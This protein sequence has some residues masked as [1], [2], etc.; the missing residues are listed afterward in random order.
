[1]K[2]M[3]YT[4]AA[5]GA[6]P[7]LPMTVGYL[8]RQETRVRPEGHAS[9]QLLCV[10]E[11]SGYL[12]IGGERH[13]LGAGD[14]IFLPANAPHAYGSDNGTLVTSWISFVG[15]GVTGLYAYFGATAPALYRGRSGGAFLGAL[16]RLLEKMSDMASPARISHAAF[17][18][19]NCFFEEASAT[20]LTPAEEIKAYLER[21]FNEHL[22]LD[23][24]FAGRGASHSKLSADFKRRFGMTVFEMLT[25]IRLRHA[26]L[27]LESDTTLKS[28][29][30]GRECGF[31]DGSYFCKMYRRAFGKSPRENKRK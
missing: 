27:L 1:M 2:T 20:T 3:I 30:V 14:L 21:H 19:F 6:L 10:N 25:D 4:E 18:A 13:V 5:M 24:I 22:T 8:H 9:H 16:S 29:E 23:D 15:G 31:T 11:G 17:G 12:I 28:A 26:Q 7:I